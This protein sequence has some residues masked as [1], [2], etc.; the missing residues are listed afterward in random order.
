MSYL[1]FSYVLNAAGILVPSPPAPPPQ[2]E[3]VPD[4]GVKNPPVPVNEQ[5]EATD[6]E[7]TLGHIPKPAMNGEPADQGGGTSSARHRAAH[8]LARHPDHLVR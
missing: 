5:H 8:D 7:C 6:C 3:P 1:D 4:E 2:P